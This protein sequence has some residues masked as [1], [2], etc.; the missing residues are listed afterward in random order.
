MGLTVRPMD[1]DEQGTVGVDAERLVRGA[2]YQDTAGN[3][4]GSST[5]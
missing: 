4:R 3:L 1:A 5:D 2:P